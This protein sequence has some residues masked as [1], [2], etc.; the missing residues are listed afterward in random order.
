MDVNTATDWVYRLKSCTLIKQVSPCELYYYAEVSLPWPA[1][2]RDFVC[3]LTVTQ[4]PATKVVTI[5]GPAVKGFVPLKTDIVRI[6]KSNGKWI[7]TPIGIDKIN[8][9]YI[10]L[11]D[12]GGSI[13]SWLINLFAT[14][15]PLQIFRNMKL[16][17]QKPLYKNIDLEF[18]EK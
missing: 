10:I 9:E 8:V 2:N 11:I 16:Q 12:P 3:H 17:L 13:P 15:G 18:V 7:I 14:Q 4:N 5:D 6:S 1:E